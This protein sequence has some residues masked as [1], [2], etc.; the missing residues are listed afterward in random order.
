MGA[1]NKIYPQEGL[2]DTGLYQLKVRFTSEKDEQDT[3]RAAK[4]IKQRL[5]EIAYGYDVSVIECAAQ[6]LL[7]LMMENVSLKS[8]LE[9]SVD[10]VTI[11]KIDDLLD[12]IEDE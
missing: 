8:N 5:K 9:Y 6:M 7:E 3:R 4:A 2:V 10:K 1:E 12:S 11:K